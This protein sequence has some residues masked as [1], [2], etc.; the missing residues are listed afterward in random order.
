MTKEEFI[1]KYH[2]SRIL[3]LCPH[4]FICDDPF[5][6]ELES[7]TILCKT[8]GFIVIGSRRCAAPRSFVDVVCNGFPYDPEKFS[9]KKSF[10]YEEFKNDIEKIFIK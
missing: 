2:Q 4:T 8:V 5:Y 10:V 3:F 1:E 9:I 7:L 6:P